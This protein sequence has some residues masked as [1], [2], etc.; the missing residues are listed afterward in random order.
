MDPEGE[1]VS[2]T[3]TS[4]INE[5]YIKVDKDEN[6]KIKKLTFDKLHVPFDTELFKS[7]GNITYI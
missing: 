5:T 1:E 4:Y 3:L 2:M 6:G 7:E